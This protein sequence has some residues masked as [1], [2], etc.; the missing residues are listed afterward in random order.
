MR[1]GRFGGLPK[2][3]ALKASKASK[4][5]FQCAGL[6]MSLALNPLHCLVSW[7][8]FCGFDGCRRELSPLFV[9]DD[10]SLSMAAPSA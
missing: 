9:Q 3:S 4:A 1:R 2:K 10:Q 8:E 6:P 5:P 7:P